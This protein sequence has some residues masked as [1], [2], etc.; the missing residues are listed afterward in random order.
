VA[1]ITDDVWHTFVCTF[2]G[3]DRAE[4]WIDGDLDNTKT[5]SVPA[6]VYA[7]SINAV[8][9]FETITNRYYCHG[10]VEWCAAWNYALSP[11]EIAALDN[12]S[13]QQQAPVHLFAKEIYTTQSTNSNMTMMVQAPSGTNETLPLY[14]KGDGATAGAWPNNASMNLFMARDTESMAANMSLFMA[15][16]NNIDTIDL[17]MTGIEVANSSIPLYIYGSGILSGQPDLDLYTHGF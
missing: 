3:S 14:V 11:T 16:N 15:Q 9:G 4:I 8:V 12:Q 5:A 1:D 10:G 7:N 2:R 17:V 13:L 6:A